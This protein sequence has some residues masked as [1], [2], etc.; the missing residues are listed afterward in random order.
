MATTRRTMLSS[1]A[2]S[3]A[4]TAGTAGILAA[5]GGPGT[6]SQT[7]KPITLSKATTIT[8]W[9]P[10]TGNYTE[11]LT[12][13]VAKFQQSQDKVKVTVEPPGDTAKLQ[14][15]IV[16]GDPPNLQQSNFIP[17]FMWQ[18]QDAL[19][20]I[21]AYLDKRGKTDYFDWA[22]DGS[23][24]KGKLY[25]WPWML[26]PTGPVINKS[27]LAERGAANL[28]PAQGAKADWTQD[29]WRAVLKAVTNVT[30]DENRDV[31]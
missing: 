14:A 9:L 4:T 16:A 25:E 13:Q 5:C 29:Q 18:I 27:L 17:M 6:T 2:A 30:G 28:A 15:S 11:Y 23:T 22:R 10:A 7:D 31:Y 24:I 12:S 3:A 21:D 1:T 26:N 20:P 19:E 8:A